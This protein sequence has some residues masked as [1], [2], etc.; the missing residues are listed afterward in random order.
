MN[1]SELLELAAMVSA[2]GPVL[3]EGPGNLSESSMEQYWTASQCRFDRWSR[4]FKELGPPA[5]ESSRNW[6]ET[7]WPTFR[8]TIEE[9][10]TGEVLTRVFGAV[11]AA[12]DARRHSGQAE[13]IARSV[14]IGHLEARNRVLRYLVSPLG[15]DAEEAFRL[16]RLRRRTERWSDMLVGYLKEL[17]D[18]RQFA[19]DPQRA[20]DFAEDLSYRQRLPGG[21]HAWTLL[22]ASLQTAFGGGLA[23]ASPNADLNERI[24]TS[25]LSCFRSELFDSTGMLHSLWVTRLCNGTADVHGMIDH[26][27]YTERQAEFDRQ[28]EEA[29]DQFLDRLRRF[30][31]S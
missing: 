25:V 24:A 4:T 16:N 15:I 11:V 12:Y 18:V 9:V 31:R 7:G 2:H 6:F 29:A 14:M 23:P 5:G 28:E 21:R 26:L 27:L 22:T 3:V 30:N 20:T 13:P 1:S 17:V 8:A 19:V 10:L